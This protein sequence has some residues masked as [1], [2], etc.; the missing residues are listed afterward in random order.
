MSTAVLT[1]TN[2]RI[3]FVKVQVMG[4]T[5]T[6]PKTHLVGAVIQVS[7]NG[8]LKLRF[9][10]PAKARSLSLTIWRRFCARSNTGAKPRFVATASVT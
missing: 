3:G 8:L 9:R 10:T 1:A 7:R 2:R 6:E 5:K 4:L